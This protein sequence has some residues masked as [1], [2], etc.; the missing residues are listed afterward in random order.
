[1]P[2]YFQYLAFIVCVCVFVNVS[3]FVLGGGGRWT[4]LLILEDVNL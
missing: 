3:C 2:F 1:M 4:V